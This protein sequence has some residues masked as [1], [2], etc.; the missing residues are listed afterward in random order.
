M[1]RHNQ[2]L[3]ASLSYIAVLI[4]ATLSIE[5]IAA[6]QERV[7]RLGVYSGY[8]QPSYDGWIR[9]SQY[10]EARDGTLLAVDYFRPTKDGEV[11][12][13][14]L[15]VVWTHTRY[16]RA[17]ITNGEMLTVLDYVPYLATLLEHGYVVGMVDVRGSGASFGQKN[18]WFPPDEAR[19]AYDVTEW[20]AV[21]P[22]SD[23]N[24]GMFSRSYLGITQYFA[25][26]EAPPHL[27]AIFPEMA[28]FDTYAFSYPG[29][30]FMDW[31]VYSWGTGVSTHDRNAALPPNWS[32]LRDAYS[33]G[34]IAGMTDIAECPQVTCTSMGGPAGRPVLPVDADTDGALLAAATASHKDAPHNYALAKATPFRDSRLAD[35]TLFN[36]ERSP[37]TRMEGIKKSGVAAYHLNGWYDAFPKDALLWYRNYPN[38]QKLVIGPWYHGEVHPLDLGAEYHRWFDYWL[39]GIENGVLDEDPIHY[40][41]LGAPRGKEWRSTSEW[42]LPNEERQHFYFD[43]GPSGSAESVN[44]GKLIVEAPVEAIVADEYTV[45][46]TTSVGI[47]NR[48]THT[49]GGGGRTPLYSGLTRNE[50]RGLT[51]TT[52]P[53]EDEIEIT[54]HPVVHLW[55]E[56][57]SE[58][59][60]FFVYLTELTADGKSVYRSEG[61][62]RASHRKLS[63]APFDNFGLP[64]QRSF[65]EDI[66]SLQPGEPTELVFDLLP[67]SALFHAGSRIRITI[68]CADKD[69]YDTPIVT[70]S[71]QVSILRNADHASYIELPVIPGG[72]KPANLP[73]GKVSGL[74]DQLGGVD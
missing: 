24:I 63:E 51:Y 74:V 38:A 15:P 67:T 34:L 66:H 37:Y 31:V 8:T 26:S 58:D 68:T 16:Q 33:S 4:T 5:S 36:Y 32:T 13:A 59:V 20:F 3:F 49:A 71:P 45:D 52:E 55:V 43:A 60:D 42:P 28:W 57:D 14:P 9:K 47:D 23:G 53:L 12:E 18:G 61:K 2:C 56:S 19:D 21:Q 41:T 64:F 50:Q 62:L 70:P 69:T 39:K 7:S 65:R 11:E 46:Y 10:V 40:W 73:P 30:I 48:W 54:G 22:F 17:N 27:K 44:D 35:G 25:A 72:S 29:G 6:E 1:T